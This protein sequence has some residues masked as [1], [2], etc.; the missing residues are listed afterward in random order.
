MSPIIPTN[1]ASFGVRRVVPDRGPRPRDEPRET[2][3][4]RDRILA[5]MP[6]AH[7]TIEVTR[8]DSCS[9][10]SVRVA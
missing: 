4:Y 7:L 1:R 8:C 5:S 10:R 2:A 3:F 9:E 6:L